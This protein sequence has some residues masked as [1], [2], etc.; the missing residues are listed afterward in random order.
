LTLLPGIKA[1]LRAERKCFSQ[2][3]RAIRSA[4][5]AGR[6]SPGEGLAERRKK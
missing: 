5:A 2:V 1:P 6:I 3:R 4:V